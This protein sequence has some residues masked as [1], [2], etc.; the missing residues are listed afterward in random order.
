MNIA[1]MGFIPGRIMEAIVTTYNSDGS[2]NA[3]PIGIYPISDT[4]I[5]MDIHE[6]TDTRSNL[7]RTGVC[8]VNIV[9]DPH[10]FLKCAIIG[11]G[12]GEAENEIAKDE[13]I[14]AEN[15]D[16]PAL[17]EANAWIELKMQT[18]EEKTKS[19]MHGEMKFSRVKCIVE[20]ITINKKYPI[21]INRGLFAAIEAAVAKSRGMPV[22]A[23]HIEIMQRTLSPEEFKKIKEL[24]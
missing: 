12:K 8:V 9:F 19:D 6:P 17:K 20:N 15:V 5:Q 24:L 4:E 10:L 18:S 23:R 13:T 14:S 1:D 2:P 16:A 22:D 3:A 11:S 7:L 21:A